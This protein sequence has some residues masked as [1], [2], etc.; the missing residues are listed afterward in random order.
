MEHSTI[1]RH[2]Q[3]VYSRFYTQETDINRD[4][5][6]KVS[7]KSVVQLVVKVTRETDIKTLNKNNMEPS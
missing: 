1:M 3:S 5:T 6:I 2:V 4:H 7:L